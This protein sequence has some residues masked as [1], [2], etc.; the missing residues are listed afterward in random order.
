ML[1]HKTEKY[2]V[3]PTSI[4]V[5]RLLAWESALRFLWNLA[6]EQRVIGMR[7]TDKRY[8]SAFDQCH[9][10]TDLRADLPWLADVPRNVCNQLL[11][12][13]DKAWQR[14]FKRLSGAP[15]WKRKGHDFLGLCEPHPKVWRLD[16]AV[17]RFPKLGSLRAVVHRP[18][19][20]KAK[21][22]T[23]KRDGDQWFAC[24]ACEVEIADPAPRTEPVVALDR[25]V[26]NLLADSDGRIVPNPKFLDRSLKRIA[27]AQRTVS[28]CKKGS[29]NR[30]KAKTRVMRLHRKARRQRAHVLHVE[31]ARYA[32]SHGVVVIEKLNVR[33]MVKNRHLSRHIL[34]AGWG[35]FASMLRYKTAWVGG[36]TVEVPAAYSSQTCAACGCVDAASRD[37]ERFACTGCGAVD[38]ADVNAAKVLKQR[39]ANRSVQPTEA[40]ATA[41]PR[42]GKVKLRSPRRSTQ[43]LAFVPG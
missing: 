30:E 22:C 33:G 5:A 13:L 35:I 3:Y 6:N 42:S 20:G 39:R 12:E 17:L 25:G 38:N 24:I 11:D 16:G 32:K 2:R 15:R 14:C 26:T 8:Y 43:V 36:Q 21:T 10:L 1:V 37:G 9:G 23:L 34:D 27:R 31:S 29:C 7:R 28:R 19:P 40:S 4:Q 41:S 18:L